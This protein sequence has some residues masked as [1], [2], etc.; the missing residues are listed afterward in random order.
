MKISSKRTAFPTIGL[1][2]LIP[3]LA[4]LLSGCGSESS[5]GR[6]ALGQRLKEHL[7]AYETQQ[8][9]VLELLQES[10]DSERIARETRILVDLSIPII[11]IYMQ[12]NPRSR[13][14][15]SATKGVFV[16]L[17]TINEEA[18]ERDY[19]DEEIL[20]ARPDDQGTSYHIKDLLV[21]PATVLVLLREEGL[22]T[23][24][25]D[26]IDEIRRNVAHVAGVRVA[27]P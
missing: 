2:A 8:T 6:E 9:L 14:F 26:M 13:A 7:N 24:R 17:D 25:E 19:H 5:G 22:E 11:D 18:I 12:I 10:E 20:P 1:I 3:F 27:F 4:L 15:L 21:H 23:R 16:K